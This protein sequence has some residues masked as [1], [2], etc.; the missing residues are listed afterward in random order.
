MTTYSH[1]FIGERNKGEQA[2]KERINNFEYI[3]VRPNPSNGGS[4]LVR[5]SSVI[6]SSYVLT[7]SDLYGKIIFSKH[8]SEEELKDNE[9]EINLIPFSLVSIIYFLKVQDSSTC[10][11]QN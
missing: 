5:F 10:T 4:I 3:S 6:K 2:E 8:I 11:F 7:L 1:N 9:F